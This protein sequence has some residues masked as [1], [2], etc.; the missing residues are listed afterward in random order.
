MNKRSAIEKLLKERQRD[1]GFILPDLRNSKTMQL[2]FTKRNRALQQ[3]DLTNTAAFDRWLFD[4]VLQGKVGIGGFMEDRIVYRRSAHYA[5]EEA[6]SVHLGIDLWTAVGTPVHA[7]WEGTIHSFRD[8]EG[9]GNYGPTI[10]MEHM[11]AKQTF[12]TLYGHLSRA[13]LTLAVGQTISKNERVGDIGTYPENGD[14]PPHLHFQVMTDSLGWV[15][16]FPGVVAPSQQGYYAKI[17]MDPA[18]LIRI[19]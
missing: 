11:V 10:I 18:F 17:C 3:I 6:R 9:F 7:P 16:D 14:W 1:I 13:S 2:D 4:D 5:G 19:E 8:N 12:Y 15:G